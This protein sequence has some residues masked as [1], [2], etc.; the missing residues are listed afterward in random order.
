MSLSEGDRLGHYV[1]D[2]ALGVGGMGE[3]YRATDTR[4]GRKV[5]IKVLPE[6]VAADPERLAR[7]E[8]EAKLLASLNHPNIAIL[9]G[10]E[11]AS[12]PNSKM[13]LGAETVS[14]TYLVMELVEGEDLALRIA[15][16]PIPVAD[17]VEIGRQIA[18]G[19]EAAHAK[20]IVHRDLKPGNVRI[21][22]DGAIKILDFGLAKVWAPEPDGANYSESPTITGELTRAGAILGTALYLSPEQAVGKAVDQ[23]TDIWAFGCV[24][25]EMLTGKRTFDGASSTEILAHI[26]EREP[27]WNT[28]PPVTPV[29]LRRL[30]GRCLQKQPKDRLR[31]AG[32]VALALED[33]DLEQPQPAVEDLRPGTGLLVKLLPWALAAAAAVL[34]IVA[35]FGRPPAAATGSSQ[36]LCFTENPPTPIEFGVLVHACS[37]VAL[38]PN[39][40]IMVWVGKSGS[41]TQLY[42]RRLDEQVAEPLAGTEGAVGPF[43]SPDGRWIGF[44]AGDEKLMKIDVSGG[45]PQT[46]CEARHPHGATWGDGIIVMGGPSDNTLWSVDP[47]SGKIQRLKA[48][49]G[50]VVQGAYPKLLPGSKKLLVSTEGETG[51]FLVSLETGEVKTVVKEGSDATYVPTGHLVW[52]QGDNLLAAPFDPEEGTITG[53]AHTVV[54]GVLREANFPL[55][56][57]AVSENGTLAYIPG[58]DALLGSLPVWVGLDGTVEHLDLPAS[59]Y[60][61]PRVAPDGRRLIFSYHTDS[62]SIWLA[63]PS[64]RIFTPVTDAQ[65]IDFWAIWTPGGSAVIFNSVRG[66]A[67]SNLWIQPVDRS[68]PA[69]RLSTA[70]VHQPP[71][72]ITSDGRTVLFTSAVSQADPNFDVDTLDLEGDH[73]ISPLLASGADEIYPSLSPDD[74]WLAYVSDISGDFEV[75]VQPFPD[76]GAIVRVSPNGGREPLWAPS[77]NR[78]YYRSADGRRVF[79]VDVLGH[80]PLRFGPEK[81]LF[82]GPFASGVLWGSKWDIHP[83]GDRFLMLQTENL[84]ATEGIRVI[85]NWVD[86]LQRLVP[87]SD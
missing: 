83:D 75:Y 44:S 19:L 43:F 79:A 27:E 23:R 36:V 73:A 50:T 80:D 2:G 61:S 26:L 14:T 51:V 24:M 70:E 4:L 32:D 15:R 20:G 35:W 45:A 62:R 6:A 72:D 17:A 31:S 67:F 21:T 85:V 65:A 38:S 33:L 47:S 25:F 71:Q 42:M 52:A 69:T 37:A 53:E 86:K 3:V 5:A 40:E 48:L 63:E 39:G 74:R 58:T 87:A 12:A 57:Y 60:L 18:E 8:R 76:L 10:L 64:R 54:E 78:L 84:E 81:L 11:S 9:H 28:L 1:I 34:A 66:G 46:I 7:F 56:H 29:G 22:E 55:V 13:P 68:A 59:N 16:G 77:G 82:E 49:E 41:S 30:L